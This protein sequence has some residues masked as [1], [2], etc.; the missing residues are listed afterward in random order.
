MVGVGGTGRERWKGKRI[1]GRWKASSRGRRG[2]RGRGGE[3]GGRG[4]RNR[5]EIRKGYPAPRM[6]ILVMVADEARAS[7]GEGGLLV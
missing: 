3:G 5:T 2:G 4:A 6:V 7:G 1:S